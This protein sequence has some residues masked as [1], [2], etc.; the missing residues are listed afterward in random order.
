MGAW[1][2]QWCLQ[3]VPLTHSGLQ[4]PTPECMRCLVLLVLQW[5]A[6]SAAGAALVT[7]PL[8]LLLPLAALY[9]LPA[10]LPPAVSMRRPPARRPQ[11]QNLASLLL[12]QRML[13]L[14][15]WAV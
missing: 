10:H 15:S 4:G 7:A 14:P 11:S 1:V 3:A 8:L 12:V 13:G 5:E 9:S 2:W 6:A